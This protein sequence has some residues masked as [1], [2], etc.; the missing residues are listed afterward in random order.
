[1][2]SKLAAFIEKRKTKPSCR[3]LCKV[4]C[5]GL[6]ISALANF[7]AALLMPEA[8][9]T[10]VYEKNGAVIDASHS[11]Q[12][13]IMV[14]HASD[15][16]QKMRISLKKTNLTYDLGG[17]GNLEPFPLQLGDGKYKVEIFEQISGKKYS[18]V[19]SISFDA[20]VA[21]EDLPFL[22]PSQ[23]VSYHESSQAV[24][25]SM[26]LCAG[27]ETDAQKVEAIYRYM[28]NNMSY[29]YG[30]A[31]E[32]G[33]GQHKGYLPTVDVTLASNTGVC[34]DFSALLACMLRTQ[35]IATKLVIGFADKVYHAWNYIL[36]DG[37]WYQYDITADICQGQA[38]KSY[39]AERIY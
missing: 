27:A 35:G 32:V 29:D 30:F 6:V 21:S 26:E 22:Y 4:L 2:Y 39:T 5:V 11:D 19:A 3:L 31:A 17:S 16:P 33:Q 8:P 14:G 9:G 23:Y 15:K 24:Q 28:L 37:T 12:G 38:A 34:F 7:A 10:V 36:I 20:T 18:T 1:M 25:T 13:Y